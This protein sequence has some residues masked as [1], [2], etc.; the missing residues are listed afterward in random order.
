MKIRDELFLI[1]I[2]IILTFGITLQSINKFYLESYYIERERNQILLIGD[3]LEKSYIDEEVEKLENL[4]GIKVRRIKYEETKENFLLSIYF[5]YEEIQRLLDGQIILN[6]RYSK[7]NSTRVIVYGKYLP[8]SREI[9]I[10]TSHVGKIKNSIN[11]YMKFTLNIVMVFFGVG[12][13]LAYFLSR[14]ITKPVVELEEVAKRISRL[15]FNTGI[16]PAGN[17]E[18]KSLGHSIETMR[19]RLKRALLDLNE[20]NEKLKKD[21]EKEKQIDKMRRNFIAGVNHELK[22]PI[23]IINSYSYALKKKIKGDEDKEFYCDV[24]L[25]EVSKME[26]MVNRLMLLSKA[27]SGF[28][29]MRPERIDVEGELT[30]LLEK[31]RGMGEQAGTRIEASLNPMEISFD[32]MQFDIVIDNLMSNAFKYVSGEKRVAMS[33]YDTEEYSVIEI[34]NTCK[35]I[36]EEKLAKLWDPF[37]ILDK[38]RSVNGKSTGL[39]LALVKNIVEK[40]KARCRVKSV[41]DGVVFVVEIEKAD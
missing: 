14:R 29:E 23:T 25:D 15:D 12:I 30:S 37:Y 21:I 41:E 40:N 6:D 39:G 11:I 1:I 19:N 2:F 10:I 9:L 33:N 36:D 5:N 7:N 3:S 22:T 20:A 28:L 4:R 8:K 38:S 18:I 24:I 32:R 31:Y 16:Q 17:S 26:M 34:F 13:I 35:P 27:E